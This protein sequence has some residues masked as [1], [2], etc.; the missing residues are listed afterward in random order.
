MTPDPDP[1][2]EGGSRHS[3]LP[4][5]GVSLLLAAVVFAAYAPSWH[6]G[7]I[8]DDDTLITKNTL[9]KAPD[10]LYSFWFTTRPTDYWPATM[11]ALWAEWRLWGLNPTGYHIFNLCLH[12]GSSLL[13]WRI[14]RRLR[15]PGAWLA[16]FIFGVHPVNVESVAW[17]AQIKN[18]LSQAFFMLSVYLFLRTRWFE[19]TEGV[20]SRKSLFVQRDK[21]QFPRPDPFYILSL[22]AFL[23]AMLSK[24][25]VAVLPLILLGIIAWRRPLKAGDALRIA[26]FF[27]VAA[28]LT[29][30]NVHFQARGL[31]TPIRTAGLVERLLGAGAVIW[32]YLG[33]ALLPLDLIFVYPQWRISADNPLWW[34]PLLAALAV[35]GVLWFRRGRLKPLFFAWLYFCAGLIPVMGLTD[36]YFMKFSLVADHYEYVAMIGVAVAAGSGWS[37]WARRATG[38]GALLARSAAVAAV[39]ILAALT[40]RQSGIYRDAE[41]LYRVT[42]E[43]NPLCW[44]AD[45]NLGN[46]EIDSGRRTQAFAHYAEALR[47]NPDYGEAHF[48]LGLLLKDAGDAPAA[49]QH[50]ERAVELRPDYAPAH[51]YFANSLRGVGRSDEAVA[52]YGLALRYKA[53][54]PEAENNMGI[55][56][57][58]AGRVGEALPHF[59]KAVLLNPGFAEAQL[60]LAYALRAVGRTDEAVAHFSEAVRLD[61]RNGRLPSGSP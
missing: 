30:V 50:F 54:F 33:K 45:N 51:Y 5:L 10:G 53:D 20:G 17:I 15:I 6:G 9:L 49:L 36:I 58:S 43:R 55:T 27:A 60:N 23:L 7:F 35:T 41:T 24:G 37:W 12:I 57:A 31:I 47:L 13:L 1:E 3:G 11:T 61:P 56:L 38:G 16:A 26:A 14:L 40:W 4:G 59:E 29:L 34:L 19:R 2:Q 28:A 8:F 18:T 25:S 44:L 32:F 42:L 21:Y 48:N 52:Q 46:V 22:L 39:G